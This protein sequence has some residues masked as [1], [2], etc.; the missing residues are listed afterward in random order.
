MM[1]SFITIEKLIFRNMVRMFISWGVGK[2][3]DKQSVLSIKEF[4]RPGL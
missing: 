4:W 3:E 2:A 1:A